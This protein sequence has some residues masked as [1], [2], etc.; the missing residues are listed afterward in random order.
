M[1]IVEYKSCVS[2][3]FTLE[4]ITLDQ[5]EQTKRFLSVIVSLSTRWPIRFARANRINRINKLVFAVAT[6]NYR[7]SQFFAERQIVIRSLIARIRSANNSTKIQLRVDE[8]NLG[9]IVSPETGARKERKVLEESSDLGPFPITTIRWKWRRKGS[10]G[11]L[12]GLRVRWSKGLFVLVA[13]GSKLDSA[14]AA[15]F[16]PLEEGNAAPW[17]GGAAFPR[18]EAR[19]LKTG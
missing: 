18:G 14:Q 19:A 1:F 11:N 3:Q 9:G 17:W 10:R 5:T 4:I 15:Y 16:P 8:L 12:K 6:R 13:W 2:I 7:C